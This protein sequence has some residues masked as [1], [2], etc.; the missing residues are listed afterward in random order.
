MS[1]LLDDLKW[2]GLI[3]QETDADGLADTLNK[4]KIS[5]Y[6]GVDPTADSM[7]I[8]HLLPF[9]TLRRFQNHGHRPIVL[10][11]GATGLIGDPSG[12]KEERKLQTLEQVD[13]NVQGLK[14]QLEQIFDFQGEN[15]AILTNNFDWVGSMDLI[16]FLRDYGKNIGV[17]YMLAKDI[18]SSRLDSGI[19]F[20][21]FTYT[22]LQAIDFYQLYEN[23]NCK[24]QI[25]GSDQWGNITTGLEMIRK[26]AGEGAKA[27]GMTIPLVTKADG[28]KFGKTESGAIWLDPV[29][30]TPYEFYQFWINTSDAD[31][32]KYLKLFTF[33]DR[34]EIEELEKSI[35]TE[36][37]LRKAQRTLAE[38]M[39]RL[40]HGDEALAQAIRITE[41][42]FSGNI[43]SLSAKEI[44]QG[45]KDVPTFEHE[46]G[47]DAGLVEILVQAKISPSKRQARE[48]IQNGA[49]SINGEKTTDLN[50]QLE[51]ED[52]LDGK[53]T[54]IRRGKKKYFLIQYK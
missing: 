36:A 35:Q 27:Y 49:V 25:G 1:T 7:H 46:E 12:K 28:T 14:K 31:V 37:H 30:T 20:T 54:V 47:M 3:Y 8:G 23:W 11:G 22:I 18:V 4:E 5:L 50:Y 19:S 51:E 21:E 39:T 16:T 45:L 10:V 13:S 17:N 44:E 38:E 2:R 41:A 34:A 26:M 33:L 42:L 24:M 43:A 9:L 53:F 15:G 32:I 48:D 6:C 52:K 40:I 29:K